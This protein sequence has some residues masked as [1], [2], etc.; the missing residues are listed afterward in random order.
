MDIDITSMTE[1]SDYSQNH[2][3][4]HN[5]NHN[6]HHDLEENIATDSDLVEAR[7]ENA[8][9]NLQRSNRNCC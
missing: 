4:N 5:H 2:N 1:D 8:M 9:Y 7:E 6:G 3:Y